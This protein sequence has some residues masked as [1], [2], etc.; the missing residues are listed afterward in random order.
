M[1]SGTS[2]LTKEQS[3]EVTKLLRLEYE[4]LKSMG[5]KEEEMNVVL[6]SK[7]KEVIEEM[8]MR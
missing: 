8:A 4:T 6:N 2:S 5:V 1:G 7:F 3:A